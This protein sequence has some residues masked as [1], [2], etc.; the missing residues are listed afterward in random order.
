[1]IGAKTGSMV[2]VMKRI[3]EAYEEETDR[4]LR[5]SVLILEPT[6]IAILSIFIGL[7]LFTFVIPL[8][9]MLF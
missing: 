5:R 9:K 1:L 2:D 4:K 8:L 7:I 3:S 6:L